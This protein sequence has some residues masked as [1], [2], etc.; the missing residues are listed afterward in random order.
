MP[1][2]NW[3][4]VVEADA[5]SLIAVTS[6]LKD[7]G[8]PYKRNTTGAGVAEMALAMQ[9]KPSVILLGLNLPFADSFEILSSLKSH[10]A[11][12]NIPVIAL[13]DDSTHNL[14]ARSARAGC[15]AFLQKP[16]PRRTFG[17]VLKRVLAGE[18]LWNGASP[19]SVG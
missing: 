2:S 10:R 12:A 7:L 14:M 6:L 9:P 1:S 8:I 3:A 11:L 19:A 4:L 17:N 13:A 16:L 18:R 15:A 5:H